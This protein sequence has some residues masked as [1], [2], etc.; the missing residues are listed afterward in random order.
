MSEK[1]GQKKFFGVHGY[2]TITRNE[3]KEA[4]ARTP[5]KNSTMS[6]Y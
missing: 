4:G 3:L 1:N 6:R 5:K 2:S